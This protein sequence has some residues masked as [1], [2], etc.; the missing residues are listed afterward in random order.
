MAC[1]RDFSKLGTPHQEE[2][3]TMLLCCARSCKSKVRPPWP[4]SP[5]PRFKSRSPSRRGLPRLASSA[6]FSIYTRVGSRRTTSNYNL[7]CLQSTVSA[8]PAGKVFV[9]MLC[10]MSGFSGAAWLSRIWDASESS[11]LPRPSAE[12]GTGRIARHTEPQTRVPSSTS[13]S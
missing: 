6:L 8:D 11:S 12:I 3:G 5:M 1:L 9:L 4:M 13:L 2:L 10:R 7:L